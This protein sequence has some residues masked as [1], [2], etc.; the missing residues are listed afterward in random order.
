MLERAADKDY[1][2]A[3]AEAI[4]DYS[5]IDNT[6]WSYY[7]II[8]ASNSHLYNKTEGVETWTSVDNSANYH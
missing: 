4:I 1:V 6:R 3:N 8:E 7:D 5:D 2:E